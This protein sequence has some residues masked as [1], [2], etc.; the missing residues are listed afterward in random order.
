EL[1]DTVQQRGIH[2]GST[3]SGSRQ[4]IELVSAPGFESR[5][6]FSDDDDP[7]D[8]G[9]YGARFEYRSASD[10]MWLFGANRFRLN[11]GNLEVASGNITA[12]G[13]I[14]AAGL[15]VNSIGAANHTATIQGRPGNDVITRFHKS[16]GTPLV[17][18]GDPDH[19]NNGGISFIVNSGNAKFNGNIVSPVKINGNAPD[20]TLGGHLTIGDPDFFHMSFTNNT[21]QVYDRAVPNQTTQRLSLNTNGG[22]VYIG[23]AGASRVEVFGTF[24]NSSDRNIKEDFGEVAPEDVLDRLVDLPISTWRYK[25][26]ETRRHVGPM[27]QD[28]HAAFDDLLDLNSDDKTI[29]PLDEAGVAFASIQALHRLVEKKDGEIKEMKDRLERMEKALAAIAEKAAR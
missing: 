21:I 2:F 10:D 22:D 24:V 15:L 18:V 1:D 16:D 12:S 26:G 23:K 17:S 28:F 9:N 6:D 4:H 7:F 11:S 29:A 25:G 13:T 8:N 14:R 19:G 27:A 20:I 5:I 3:F